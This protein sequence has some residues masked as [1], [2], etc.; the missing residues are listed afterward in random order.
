MEDHAGGGLE[1]VLVVAVE[2]AVEVVYFGAQRE[3]GIEAVVDTPAPG[4][5]KCRAIAGCRLRLQ[6]RPADDHMAPGLEAR[7]ASADAQATS[8]AK[9]FHVI[10][11]VR[12]RTEGRHHAALQPTNS[13]R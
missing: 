3:A 2:I 13:Q 11:G 8:A 1:V 12:R 10:V 7:A 4:D 6:V 5:R 9:I